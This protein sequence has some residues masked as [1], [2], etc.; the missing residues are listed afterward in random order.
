M[1]NLTF[2]RQHSKWVAGILLIV[3]TLIVYLPVKDHQFVD[4]DDDLYVTHNPQTQKG[5][6][7][8]NLAWALTALEA[9]FWHPLTWWSHMLDYELF[10][11]NPGG[12]HLMSL[13]IHVLNVLLLFGLL[14]RWTGALW[15]SFFVAALFALHP[16]NVESVAWVA[17]RKNVLSTLF[18]LLTLGAYV[19]YVRK[20]HWQRYLSVV[21][22]FVL[23]L[24]AK[25]M[26][27]TLPCVLL[28]LDYW[29]LGRL[30]PSW[31]E[32]RQK[33]SKLLLEK[34]PLFALA[35]VSGILAIQA[36]HLLGALPSLQEISLNARLGNALTSF[37]AYLGKM[38]WPTDLAVFYPH[39]EASLPVGQ[40]ILAVLVIATLSVL[41]LRRT[42]SYP[43]LLVGWLWYLGT[44]LP[45]S[46]LIQVGRHSMADRYMYVPLI[47]LFILLVW[48]CTQW[49]DG[50]RVR[51]GW[52]IGASV[53]LLLGLSINTRLQ[54]AHWENSVTLFEHAIRSTEDNYLAHN[55]LGTTFLKAG[56]IDK[57]M[58]QLSIALKI[59]PESPEVLYNLGLALKQKGRLDGAARYFS[60]ALDINPDLADAHNN[61][62]IIHMAQGD[63]EKAFQHLS[64]ALEI[65]PQLFEAHNNLGTLLVG[66]GQ[67]EEAIL[68]FSQSLLLN[69][70]QARAYN[71]LGAA[72][73]LQGQSEEAIA[74]YHRALELAP[75]S[76]L[77]HNNLGKMFMEKGDLERAARHFSKVIEIEPKFG[78]AHFNLGMVRTNQGSIEK[79]VASFRQ[80]LKLNPNNNEARQQLALLLEKTNP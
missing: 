37:V 30:G 22:L 27:V 44:L 64:K 77:T 59:K 79:A 28:L 35:L 47:G 33:G 40:V 4:L 54:L 51:K 31:S 25:P 42:P 18:W 60:Q 57:G 3:A 38:V 17:E 1:N 80:A 75:S 32:F 74:H 41:V 71:N 2:F 23:G 34:A 19:H 63:G 10:G 78:D 29:P 36:Q 39:P 73:E 45:V 7:W 55:N 70:N 9:G 76:Y 15:R 69:P 43:Y 24:M 56:K 52:G 62:G 21:V 65:D 12:H 50:F 20:P 6:T 48:G 13:L 67:V 26:L 61:L 53:F 16:L 46:G 72:L 11:L 8:A 5:L 58:E 49:L 66:N 68:R 14:Q